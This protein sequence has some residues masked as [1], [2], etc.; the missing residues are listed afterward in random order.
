MSVLKKFIFVSLVYLI[1]GCSLNNFHEFHKKN[2]FSLEIKTPDDRHNVYFKENLKRLFYSENNVNN[3]YILK[4]NI[5]F[6]S[7]ETLSISGQSILKSTKANISYQLMNK[8]TNIVLKSGSINTFPAL[9]SS[10]SSLFT[11]EKSIEHIKER[12]TKSSARSLYKHINI[13]IKSLS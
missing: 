5:S 4:T 9:S 11:K 10:S 2:D 12:L 13:L 8:D 6:Q 7:I 1:S 3:K